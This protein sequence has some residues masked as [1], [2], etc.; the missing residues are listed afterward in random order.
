LIII[1]LSAVF[2]F[3]RATGDNLLKG[4]KN[5]ISTQKLRYAENHFYTGIIHLYRCSAFRR[6]A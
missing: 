6:I 5:C 2:L 3:L 1:Q 4:A